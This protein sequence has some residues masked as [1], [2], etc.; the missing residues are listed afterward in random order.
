MYHGSRTFLEK[1]IIRRGTSRGFWVAYN[2]HDSLMETHYACHRTLASSHLPSS[3][4]PSEDA[5]LSTFPF[6]PSYTALCSATKCCFS[7]LSCLHTNR[8]D[9]TSN[10]GHGICI[11]NE[12][13][14]GSVYVRARADNRRALMLEH[15]APSRIIAAPRA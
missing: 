2:D 7:S 9:D 11:T 3:A 5:S 14:C 10:D 1:I 15:P 4:R 12:C 8:T 6:L 13:V